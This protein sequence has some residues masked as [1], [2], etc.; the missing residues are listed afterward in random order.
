MR[1]GHFAK[2]RA[3]VV[4]ALAAGCGE[5][6]AAPV[7]STGG[8]TITISSARSLL[9][10]GDSTRFLAVIKDGS[11]AV[12]PGRQLLWSSSSK[13]VAT[14]SETGLVRGVGVGV[15]TITV[16]ADGQRAFARVTITEP[17]PLPPGSLVVPLLDSATLLP[18][19]DAMPT[20]AKAWAPSAEFASSYYP[21]DVESG[22]FRLDSLPQGRW[23]LRF[24]VRHP[25]SGVFPGLQLYRDTVVTVDVESGVV[26]VLPPILMRRRPPLLLIAVETCPWAMPELPTIDDWGDCDG[27]WGGA[28]V[29][30]SVDG[31]QGTNTEGFHHDAAI[32]A[33]EPT[34]WITSWDNTFYSAF[35]E[36]PPQG[37]YDVRMVSVATDRV[38]W[39]IVPWET[40]TRRV[41]VGRPISYVQFDFWHR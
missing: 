36:N 39:R 10:V 38:P 32:G 30:I 21:Y 8:A 5:A 40:S 29:R 18:I 34:G 27:N 26:L 3:A 25:W 17:A 33:T 12:L 16:T 7:E 1:L 2:L 13:L 19:V 14:V 31:V 24:E 28:E 35:I 20:V 15:A 23:K 22:S 41:S 6:P 37:E 11:G 9:D 4:L